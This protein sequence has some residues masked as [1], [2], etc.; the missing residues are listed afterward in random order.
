[1]SAQDEAQCPECREWSPVAVMEDGGILGYW[2]V[3]STGCPRCGV[4]V[5]VETECNFYR[6]IPYAAPGRLA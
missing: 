5:L 1:M 2:W 3:D 4:V 6:G